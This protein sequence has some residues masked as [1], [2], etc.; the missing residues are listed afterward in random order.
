MAMLLRLCFAGGHDSDTEV[1]SQWA[2]DGSLALLH[3]RLDEFE[4]TPGGYGELHRR[5]DGN[6]IATRK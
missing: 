3:N 5:A 6:M 1:N 4:D 2:V